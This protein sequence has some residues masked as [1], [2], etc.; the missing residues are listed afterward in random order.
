[1]L[2]ARSE[3]ASRFVHRCYQLSRLASPNGSVSVKCP[4]TGGQSRPVTGVGLAQAASSRFAASIFQ[5]LNA[6]G[7]AW[8]FLEFTYS[9]HQDRAGTRWAARNPVSPQRHQCGLVLQKRSRHG[10]SGSASHCVEFVAGHI[11]VQS[12]QRRMNLETVERLLQRQA[13]LEGA[14]M[15]PGGAPVT[16]EHELQAVKRKLGA[17]TSGILNGPTSAR[18]LRCSLADFAATRRCADD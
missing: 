10:S 2:E 14:M 9:V 17:M 16:Q 13:E 18:A 8:R 1:M 3:G 6:V 4:L 7:R 12:D 5:C 11:D 15:Q